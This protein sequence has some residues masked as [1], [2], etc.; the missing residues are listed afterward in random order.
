MQMRVIQQW[1]LFLS[2]Q[3]CKHIIKSKTCY[4]SQEGSYID[5]II[6]SR[7]SLHQFYH[8]FKAGISDHHLMVYTMLKCKYAKLEPKVLRNSSYKDLKKESFL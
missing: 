2:Q 6:T 4:K 7:H 3:K 5:L 8:A 1:K